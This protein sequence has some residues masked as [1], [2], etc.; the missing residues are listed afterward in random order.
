MRTL[1]AVLLV[2]ALLGA[3]NLCFGASV[4]GS[5]GDDDLKQRIEK[6]EKELSDMKQAMAAQEA[7]AAAE[8]AKPVI[9][10]N[11]DKPAVTTSE[12]K[13]VMAGLDVELYGR[14]KLDAVYD[15]ARMDVG[16]YAKWVRPHRGNNDDGQ[17]DVT[18]NETR[19]GMYIYGPKNEDIKTGGRVEMDFYG[20]GA[21]NKSNPMLRHAYMTI[22]WPDEKFSILAGQTWD[23]ISPLNPDTLN[24]SVLWWAGNIGYRRPQIRLT[25]GY[26]LSKD[27]E[28][29]FEGAIERTI[30]RTNSGILSADQADTGENSGMPSL[31][32][33]VSATLPLLGYK[34]ATVG[35]SGHYGQEK[36]DTAPSSSDAATGDKIFRSWSINCDYVQPVNEW[37]TV[38]GEMY[39]GENLD[40][41]L[42][43]IGEGVRNIGTSSAPIYD[44]DIAD[45]GGWIQA[46][47]GP[48]DK[49]RFN[50]GVGVDDPKNDDLKG[51]VD[52]RTLNRSVFGNVIYA[53]DKNAEIGFEL[54]QWHT[55]YLGERGADSIRAQTSFIYKF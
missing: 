4:G 22:D 6:L 25:Q 55:E 8:A 30:G 50:V 49:W 34:P 43:G 12:K 51:G 39:K 46:G 24:Y 7:K 11:T 31:Q 33:R 35:F 21:E 3:G 38:K 32:G 23:V 17:Y 48:W 54:S 44:K 9:E 13:P 45:M 1:T 36:C 2:V 40:V 14:L 47:L 10:P 20:G 5:Q 52:K 53:I 18:A 26:T 42:G 29:K 19:L 28:L 37:L 41:Y 27:V 15:S 16:D